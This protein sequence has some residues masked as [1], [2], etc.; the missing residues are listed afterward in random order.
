MARSQ[1]RSAQAPTAPA[2]VYKWRRAGFGVP[3]QIVGQELERLEIKPGDFHRT[4]DILESASDP[5]SPLYAAFPWD[6]EQAAHQH[7]L[8][9]A[10]SMLRNITYVVIEGEK[11]E[12]RPAYIHIIDDDGPKYVRSERVSTDEEVR[13]KAIDEALMLL[14]GLRKRFEFIKEL[15]PIFRAIDSVVDQRDS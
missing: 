9:I 15:R 5:E 12:K 7:R 1:N 13:R 2:R 3:A 11:R 6:D 4:T 10:R 8:G 14:N